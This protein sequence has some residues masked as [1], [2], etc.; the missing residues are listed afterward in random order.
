[1]AERVGSSAYLTVG[2]SGSLAGVSQSPRSSISRRENESTPAERSDV[3]EPVPLEV[4]DAQL[5]ELRDAIAPLV[6]VPTDF[7]ARKI[8]EL[9]QTPEDL[10][11]MNAL[12]AKLA[13]ELKSGPDL[14][15]SNGSVDVASA[16]IARKQTIAAAK[17]RL[18]TTKKK[19]MLDDRPGLKAASVDDGGQYRRASID[20]EGVEK[21]MNDE[22]D[23]PMAARKQGT[24]LSDI[25]RDKWE[26]VYAHY[27][28]VLLR[29]AE[30]PKKDRLVVLDERL[31]AISKRLHSTPAS[32][33]ALTK[34]E[35]ETIVEYK[36]TRGKFRPALFSKVKSNSPAAIH[37]ASA[38]AFKFITD[39]RKTSKGDPPLDV[40]R[41]AMEVLDKGTKAV[42]GSKGLVG[43]GPAT[44]SI[45]LQLYDPSIAYFSDEAWWEAVAPTMKYTIKEALQLT[46]TLRAKSIEL[47]WRDAKSVGI[48]LLTY[49]FAKD[50]GMGDLLKDED[51]GEEK[52]KR[53]QSASNDSDTDNEGDG[54]SK[55]A[56]DTA[57]RRRERK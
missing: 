3:Q 57:K 25:Y 46:E 49:R 14:T 45:I 32:E 2:N 13:E 53:Q 41:Q 31:N 42:P 40:V 44:A 34:E 19:A 50:L 15:L 5:D 56:K 48:A 9:R 33:L 27:K 22:K 55:P 1:M 12:E 43:V 47:G 29:Q 18:A 36:M 38:A 51:G 54:I 11:A 30:L 10:A 20:V 23:R 17:S 35:L 6:A 28:R 24:F 8:F 7:A 26:T 4:D 16:N 52:R 21:M 39:F 37:S